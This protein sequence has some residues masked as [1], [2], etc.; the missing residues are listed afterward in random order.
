MKYE[1]RKA[2]K[3]RYF[4]KGVEIRELTEQ[5][6]LILEGEGNPNNEHFSKQIEALYSV[7][8]GIR[9]MLKK[10]L[11]TPEYEYTVYPL[12][13]VW[14]TSDDSKEE[15]L[16]KDNLVYR[17]MI[18]QPDM[19]TEEIVQEAIEVAFKKK[20]NAYIKKMTFESYS[21]GKIVQMI[22]IGSF[23]TEVETFKKIDSF[24]EETNYERDWIME[25]FV[26]RE[27]YLSD[28][29][30]VAPEKRKTLLSYQ[31]KEIE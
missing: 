14:T 18:K 20:E 8:Y 21:E 19:V 26:H 27:I 5:K 9:M 15:N 30:R 6:Y 28:F 12:E 25:K 22:H 16:N 7:S 31:L 4:P 29:R 23:D 13:G 10:G 2:E 24:L 1:W 3:S 17:I 11:Y